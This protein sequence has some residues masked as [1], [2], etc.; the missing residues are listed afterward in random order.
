MHYIPESTCEML[1]GDPLAVGSPTRSS[2]HYLSAPLYVL[3][4]GV[5]ALLVVDWWL[6]SGAVASDG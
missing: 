6:T 4:A 5:G 1:R 2:F 3:T